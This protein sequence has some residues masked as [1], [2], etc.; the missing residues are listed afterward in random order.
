MRLI[1]QAAEAPHPRMIMMVMQ[2]VQQVWEQVAMP[3]GMA[4]T[5]SRYIG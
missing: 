3:D 1:A 4:V 5:R 2:A